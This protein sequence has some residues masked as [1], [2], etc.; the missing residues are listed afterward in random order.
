MLDIP[1][2]FPQK[3]KSEQKC[4]CGEI[5]DMEHIYYCE[6]EV[7][8]PYKKIYNGDIDEQISVYKIFEENLKKKEDKRRTNSE[9]PCD[10]DVI[11]YS[12]S[13]GWN[14]YICYKSVIEFKWY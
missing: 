1:S 5:F 10:P 9:L 4:E 3:S 13:I 2:N 12:S 8:I 6:T 7:K 11:R 14:I